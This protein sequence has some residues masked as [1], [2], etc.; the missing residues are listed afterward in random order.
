MEKTGWIQKYLI[1]AYLKDISYKSAKSILN[2][3]FCFSLNIW[4]CCR[5]RELKKKLRAGL[6]KPRVRLGAAPGLPLREIKKASKQASRTSRPATSR[7]RTWEQPSSRTLSALETLHWC[8]RKL[9][10]GGGYVCVCVWCAFECDCETCVDLLRESILFHF[11]LSI[12]RICSEVNKKRLEYNT[13]NGLLGINIGPNKDTDDMLN[14][15]LLCA[16]IFFPIGDYITIN[17][18]S[19]NTEGLRNFHYK[20]NLKKL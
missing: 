5:K 2:Y 8:L 12:S 17:I 16:K 7:P 20:E 11:R 9:R 15:F 10:H 18:S 14:D 19:P 1:K 13:P 3:T 6:S 4:Y